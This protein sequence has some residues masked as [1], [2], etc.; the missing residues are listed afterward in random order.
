MNVLEKVTQWVKMFQ[1]E[2]YHKLPPH[3]GRCVLKLNNLAMSLLQ[4]SICLYIF[5]FLLEFFLVHPQ[6]QMT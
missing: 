1:S 5:V 3:N 2:L 4:I 6:N